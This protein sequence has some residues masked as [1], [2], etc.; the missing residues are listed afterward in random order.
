MA[1]IKVPVEHRQVFEESPEKAL[2]DLACIATAS[3]SGYFKRMDLIRKCIDFSY[4]NP[5]NE[6]GFV[7]ADSF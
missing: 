1:I 3:V 2:R 5:F 7:F 6:D 4:P